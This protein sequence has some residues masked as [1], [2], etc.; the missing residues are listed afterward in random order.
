MYPESGY[1]QAFLDTPAIILLIRI[2]TGYMK[3]R[4]QDILKKFLPYTKH[5]Y[6]IVV[7]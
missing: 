7:G 3:V 4:T 1:T 2:T 5:D 6:R